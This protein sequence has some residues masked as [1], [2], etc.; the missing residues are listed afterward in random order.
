MLKYAPSTQRVAD[1]IMCTKHIYAQLLRVEHRHAITCHGMACGSVL[2]TMLDERRRSAGV[3]R[4]N[5]VLMGAPRS[6]T[7][8][9][10]HNK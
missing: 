10:Y 3:G 7:I 6:S 5:P 8:E 2:V 9:N 1:C 4:K